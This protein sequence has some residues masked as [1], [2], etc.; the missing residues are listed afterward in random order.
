[1]HHERHAVRR[2]AGNFAGGAVLPLIAIALAPPTWGL[3]LAAMCLLVALWSL[4]IAAHRRRRYGESWADSLLYGSFCVL[5][6]APQ[7]LGQTR[8]MLNRLAG[9][10]S[11]LMEYKAPVQPTTHDVLDTAACR[12]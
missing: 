3:S 6:K 7:S 8:Y 10:R 5:A 9:R 12:R 2:V 4:R 11:K 1:M